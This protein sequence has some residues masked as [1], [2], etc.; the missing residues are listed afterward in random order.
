MTYDR[1]LRQKIGVVVKEFPRYMK[2]V[3]RGNGYLA[4][5]NRNEML[6]LSPD[7]SGY[8]CDWKWTSDLHAPKLFPVIGRQL[9]RR[10]FDNHPI[11]FSTAPPVV[12]QP[13]EVTFIIGH[14]GLERIPLLELTLASIA[15]QQDIAIE[16]IV[17][18]QD[19]QPL[20]KGRL[21][22]WVRYVHAPPPEPHTAYN[23]S[24]AFNQGAKLATGTLLILHD[25]DMPV[26]GDYAAANL[27][28]IGEG[29]EVV[30]LKRFIFY[31]DQPT[32]EK[33]SI[34]SGIPSNP[35]IEAIMQNSQGGG[36]IAIT[37]TA[38]FEIGGMDESFVGWGGEDNEFWERAKTRPLFPYGFMPLL[39][40][41][42]P[43]QFEKAH[44]QSNGVTRYRELSEISPLQRIAKLKEINE[45]SRYL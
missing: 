6:E 34:A 43:P 13:P 1:T 28:K 16:C 11:N 45:D 19:T 42:H 8:R 40:L 4:I 7:G 33:V 39:H 20:L 37:R 21:P 35:G 27:A 9:Y 18:E 29:Y 2:L 30:N 44:S 5:R 17:V 26:P 23:R 22:A 12:D 31:L 14:R 25:N 32:S 41:W 3:R 24:M 38:Y 10:A 36:S 15:G